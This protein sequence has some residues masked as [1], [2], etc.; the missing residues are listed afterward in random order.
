MLNLAVI[1]LMAGL[2]KVSVE[3]SSRSAASKDSAC[4]RCQMAQSVSNIHIYTY[5]EYVSL[6]KIRKEFTQSSETFSCRSS[7]IYI[8]VCQSRFWKEG[9]VLCFNM[10]SRRSYAV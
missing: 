4:V 3:S 8:D 1:E 9:H 2:P 7:D 10:L 5:Y 6:C